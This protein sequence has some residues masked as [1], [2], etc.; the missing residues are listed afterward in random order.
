MENEFLDKRSPRVQH[1]LLQL[2]KGAPPEM[3]GATLARNLAKSLQSIIKKKSFDFGQNFRTVCDG[4]GV[5]A[6]NGLAAQHDYARLL[7]IQNS[8]SPQNPVSV[9]TKFLENASNVILDNVRIDALGLCPEFSTIE[10][11]ESFREK[12]IHSAAPVLQNL[13]RQIANNP[14]RAPVLRTRKNVS[15]PARGDK[16]ELLNLSIMR[17]RREHRN[18]PPK[19]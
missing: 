2:R 17:K 16:T 6:I 1:I 4:N 15:N 5:I 10:S 14:D 3:V 19:I 9:A 7:A 11:F 8:Q 18:D 12:A 13:A